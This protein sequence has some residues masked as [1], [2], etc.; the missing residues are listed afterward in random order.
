MHLLRC[1]KILTFIAPIKSPYILGRLWRGLAMLSLQVQYLITSFL[2]DSLKLWCSCICNLHRPTSL[3]Q[4]HRSESTSRQCVTN[5][6]LPVQSQALTSFTSSSLSL[7]DNAN[8]GQL[9]L[10][11]APSS[12]LSHLS[13]SPTPILFSCL[14]GRPPPPLTAH[15]PLPWGEINT[16]VAHGQEDTLLSL[17]A[18]NVDSTSA[19]VSTS[20]CTKLHNIT[21]PVQQQVQMEN[22]QERGRRG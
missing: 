2:S 6:C 11:L 16:Q 5:V 17:L 21:L 22:R 8:G 19:L 7:H 15:R 4:V 14:P 12:L 13:S 1:E 10:N 18:N 9:L 3:C 20:P